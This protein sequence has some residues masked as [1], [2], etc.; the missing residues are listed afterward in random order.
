[1]PPRGFFLRRPN[2]STAT[3]Q[4][5]LGS[6]WADGSPT[7]YGDSYYLE[8]RAEVGDPLDEL[9]TAVEYEGA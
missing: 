2:V 3:D 9:Q 6:H 8:G 4:P 5:G 1:V 7:D